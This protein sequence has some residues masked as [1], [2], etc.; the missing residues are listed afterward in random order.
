[1]YLERLA[2]TGIVGLFFFLSVLWIGLWTAVRAARAFDRVGEDG[3][4]LIAR[5]VAVGLI[6]TFAADFFLSADLS[7]LLW[8]LIGLGPAML[9]IG[10]RL[11]RERSGPAE[12]GAEAPA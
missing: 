9:A 11:E 4:S 5:A 10:S 2:E 7:K 3:L 6:S 12:A 8:L 1:M